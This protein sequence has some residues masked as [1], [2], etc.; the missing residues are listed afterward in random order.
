M[1]ETP[2]GGLSPILV[3]FLISG[4]LGFITAGVMLMNET[5]TSPLPTPNASLNN[6]LP[7]SRPLR[8]WI[9][10]DFE[11]LSLSGETVR[12]SD[13]AGRPVFINFW[14]TGC[15][16]CEEEFPA[17]E[18]FLAEQG[19]D[20]AVILAVN[21]AGESPAEIQA[22]LDRINVHNVPILLDPDY[23]MPRLY[24]YTGFPTTYFIDA[25]G[26]VRYQK[27]GTITLEQLYSYLAESES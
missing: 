9:A 3:I 6:P 20:G 22:F 26:Q 19:D 4:A 21:Q 18:Q 14:W 10:D 13:F 7:A 8:D 1:Q 11:L 5:R 15:P 23:I 12:L 24:P 17:F 16:P 27:I 25:T 2:R